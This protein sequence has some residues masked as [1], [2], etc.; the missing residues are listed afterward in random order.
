MGESHGLGRNCDVWETLIVA[1]QFL[2]HRRLYIDS[3]YR[4]AYYPPIRR[5]AVLIR[6]A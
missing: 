5:N 2:I 1:H 6:N 4:L 3:A